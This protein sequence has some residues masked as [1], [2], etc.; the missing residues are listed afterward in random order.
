MEWFIMNSSGVRSLATGLV[1]KVSDDKYLVQDECT[2]VIDE[3]LDKIA[4]DDP[5]T[6][7]TKL[8][9][10]AEGILAK[11]LIPLI[12]FAS[13]DSTELGSVLRLMATLCEPL[14]KHII[15]SAIVRQDLHQLTLQLRNFFL[16]TQFVQ[17]LFHHIQELVDEGGDMEQPE[18]VYVAIKYFLMLIRNILYHSK[19]DDA[20]K[21]DALKRLL[22]KYELGAILIYSIICH[23]RDSL[24]IASA[25]LL[26]QLYHTFEWKETK[27]GLSEYVNDKLKCLI[28]QLLQGPLS[29]LTVSLQRQEMSEVVD[30]S[31]VPWCLA[32]FLRFISYVPVSV[33]KLRG[34]LS[35]KTLGYLVYQASMLAIDLFSSSHV[36]KPFELNRQR[37]EF[38]FSALHSLL[39]I[40]SEYSFTKLQNEEQRTIMKF[41]SD[42]V[43]MSD[44]W[45]VF[46]LYIGNLD[47]TRFP[48]SLLAQLVCTNHMLFTAIELYNRHFCGQ[49]EQ[50]ILKHIKLFATPQLI[51]RYTQL[52]ETYTTNSNQTNIAV[53]TMLCHICVDCDRIDL[54]YTPSLLKL[55]G[56]LAHN[57]TATDEDRLFSSHV[58]KSFLNDLEMR[59]QQC[60]SSLTQSV[61]SYMEFNAIADVN[62]CEMKDSQG[63]VNATISEWD[64]HEEED[65]FSLIPDVSECSPEKMVCF[66]S[67]RLSR[68]GIEKTE[69]EVANKLQELGV[70]PSPVEEQSHSST[71]SISQLVT[72]L[73]EEGKDDFVSW[74]Q[75]ELVIASFL[76]AAPKDRLSKNSPL[77]RYS[78]A[79]CHPYPLLPY[80]H[81][82][83]DILRTD[84]KSRQL[85]DMLEL[86]YQP[87][88]GSYLPYV[89]VDSSASHLYTIAEQLKS[90]EL[91]A[92]ESRLPLSCSSS[93]FSSTDEDDVSHAKIK[94][95]ESSDPSRVASSSAEGNVW[96]SYYMNTA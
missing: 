40:T 84:C 67:S 73:V 7:V 36:D 42:L 52:V 27:G 80:S 22:L 46:L 65:L 5:R 39:S 2:D 37:M 88:N 9:L 49:L 75:H 6:S 30:A 35:S 15:P 28:V 93:A 25:E 8:H 68:L 74:L 23:G 92:V 16:D 31:Y 83:S 71:T 69:K 63:P 62:N 57:P 64:H 34:V 59:P 45:R 89:S 94:S 66:L 61:P 47:S 4:N 95:G 21:R 43:E 51:E 33:T 12:K 26:S 13:P 53:F 77:C 81:R 17:K 10:L 20:V 54:L 11:D 24:A 32:Y 79:K 14:D 70:L 87:F 3:L 90:I 72:D 82:L 60:V 76:H 44:L 91:V 38:I 78:L 1:E 50:A 56:S 41:Y 86:S 58:V 18:E 29:T 48:S 96:V 19:H 85:L 55:F